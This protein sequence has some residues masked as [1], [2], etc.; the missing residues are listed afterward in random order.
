[1]IDQQCKGGITVRPLCENQ[2]PPGRYD[3]RAREQGRYAEE[4]YTALKTTCT[5]A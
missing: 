3:C 4:F 1:M 2:M 5:L